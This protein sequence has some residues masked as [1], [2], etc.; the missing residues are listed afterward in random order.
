MIVLFLFANTSPVAVELLL[1]RCDGVGRIVLR[2]F[3][4]NSSTPSMQVSFRIRNGT[5]AR[6]VSAAWPFPIE[7]YPELSSVRHPG[8]VTYVLLADTVHGSSVFRFG[9]VTCSVKEVHQVE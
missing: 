8:C 3:L 2:K 1:S 9:V 6:V 7:R 4:I 5:S